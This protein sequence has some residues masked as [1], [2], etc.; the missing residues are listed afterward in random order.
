M[1]MPADVVLVAQELVLDW[2]RTGE[3]M[4]ADRRGDGP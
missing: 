1:S 2:Y 3:P 4:G